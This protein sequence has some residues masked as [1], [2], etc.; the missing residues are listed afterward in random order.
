MDTEDK[1]LLIM[2]TGHILLGLLVSVCIGLLI[3]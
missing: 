2:H 3:I 1:K